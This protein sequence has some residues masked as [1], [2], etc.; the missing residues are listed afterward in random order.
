MKT[1]RW[2]CAAALAVALAVPSVQAQE[3]PK[4]GPEHEVLKKMEG[5]WDLTMKFGV[6]ESRGTA[7][8]KM[9][10]GGNWLI[11]E[12]DLDLFGSKFYGHGMDAYDAATKKYVSYFFASMGGR[13]RAMEGIYDND[14][15]A[16]TLTGEGPGMD[17]KPTKYRSV[18]ELPDDNTIQF[19]MWMGDGKDPFLTITYKRK[20]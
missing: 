3:G 8:Y 6:M 1:L 13:P 17:E 10:V 4:T 2:F 14:K 15:K 16:L 7:S 11:S 5:N 20:K 9:G 19:T 18:T 12:V